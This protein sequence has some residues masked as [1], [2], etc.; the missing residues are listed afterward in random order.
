MGTRTCD[1]L[2]D[3]HSPCHHGGERSL[4]IDLVFLPEKRRS[5]NW[6]VVM[7]VKGESDHAP[8]LIK[9]SF[10]IELKE[11]PPTI[12][13]GSEAKADFFLLSSN[14]YPLWT[15]SLPLKSPQWMT[16]KRL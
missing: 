14:L 4:L 7:G 9:A 3:G 5:E 15:S 16:L 8:Y 6:D 11:G 12:K 13:R 10:S 1:H 2:R